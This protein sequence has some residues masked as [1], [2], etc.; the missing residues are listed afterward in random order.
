MPPKI[1]TGTYFDY[2]L[3]TF[4]RNKACFV[5]RISGAS[6]VVQQIDN[7]MQKGKEMCETHCHLTPGKNLQVL[8]LR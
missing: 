4:L 5:R 3:I 8:Q 6:N 2:S 7:E 1:F